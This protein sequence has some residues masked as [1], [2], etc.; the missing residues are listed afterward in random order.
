MIDISSILQIPAVT[1]PA[2]ENAAPAAFEAILTN[3]QD[4]QVAPEP[5]PD[6]VP[7]V[8]PVPAAFVTS[9]A[10][11]I[12]KEAPSNTSLVS[13][14]FAPAPAP[15]KNIKP[16]EGSDDIGDTPPTQPDKIP[17]DLPLLNINMPIDIPSRPSNNLLCEPGI[18][19]PVPPDDSSKAVAK[20]PAMTGKILGWV[21]QQDIQPAVDKAARHQATSSTP[22]DAKVTVPTEIVSE[23]S[24]QPT[25]NSSPENIRAVATIP[26]APSPT[27]VATHQLDLA[28]DMM[29]LDN[30]AREI[31]ASASRE[32]R[33][34]FRLAP[35]SLGQLDVGLTHSTDGMHIQL[36]AST[37]AAARI[38]AVEQPRLVDELRQSGV[39]I[40]GSEVSTGYQNGSQKGQSAPH[41]HLPTPR[42]PNHHFQNIPNLKRSGRFA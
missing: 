1:M 35:E 26:S 10:D 39:K 25:A 27:P 14:I 42:T 38:I 6:P 24:S 3:I 13:A 34:S 8:F 19:K 21:T 11:Q 4:A 16:A 40:S 30:L 7:A 33:I 36:D 20:T 32:G 28:R 18:G 12:V 2:P 9:G 31:T 41:Q 17:A 37:D 22:A 29:W 23:V 15:P 5:K